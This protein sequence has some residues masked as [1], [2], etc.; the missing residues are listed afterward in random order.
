M[1]AFL[2]LSDIVVMMSEQETQALLY[3]EAQASGRLLLTSDVPGAREVVTDG[4]TGALFRAGDITHLA[5]RIIEIA[6]RP[7]WRAEVE[8][9]ARESVASHAL[10]TIAAWYER[11]LEA[12]ANAGPRA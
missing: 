4:E 1:P 5:D 12:T 9:K 7:A 3:L 8:G 6:S 10:P 2:S 11:T